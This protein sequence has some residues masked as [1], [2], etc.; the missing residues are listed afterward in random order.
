[1]NNAFLNYNNRCECEFGYFE[2]NNTC[3]ECYNELN[4]NPWCLSSEGCSHK[5]K[6]LHCNQCK[7]GYNRYDFGN[8]INCFL[9]INNCEKC[10]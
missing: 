7:E 9:G 8:C 5:F 1:M 3:I 2:M 10:H 4:G 6:G